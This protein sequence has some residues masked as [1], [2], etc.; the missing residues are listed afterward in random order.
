MVAFPALL[1]TVSHSTHE[2]SLFS[3]SFPDPLPHGVS[4]Y[5]TEAR[6]TLRLLSLALA[7]RIRISWQ[8]T[9]QIESEDR[10]RVYERHILFFAAGFP[11]LLA[12]GVHDS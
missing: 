6:I 3:L 12:D 11:N 10:R 9:N 5:P 1:Y 2:H 4:A 7:P 8:S